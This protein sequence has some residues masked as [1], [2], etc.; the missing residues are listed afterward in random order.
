M[1]RLIEKGGEDAQSDCRNMDFLLGLHL[2][3]K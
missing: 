1:R 3:Q 2:S